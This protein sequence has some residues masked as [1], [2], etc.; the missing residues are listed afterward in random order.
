M[1]DGVAPLLYSMDDAPDI[2][3]NGVIGLI[4]D[5]SFPENYAEVRLSE[6]Y[7][8][9]ITRLL[10]LVHQ[11]NPNRVLLCPTPGVNLNFLPFL[12]CEGVKV[13]IVLPTKSYINTFP[14]CDKKTIQTAM[15]VCKSVII[16]NSSEQTTIHNYLSDVS[17]AVKYIMDMSD[18]ILFAH[19]DEVNPQTQKLL[20]ELGDVEVPTVRL[21]ITKRISHDFDL[22]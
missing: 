12:M 4:G 13:T 1:G 17:N 9:A 19:C 2:R 18:W 6:K 16:L 14:D 8:T 20:D 7:E 3:E 10:M 5:F 11:K 15:A 21:N 22:S